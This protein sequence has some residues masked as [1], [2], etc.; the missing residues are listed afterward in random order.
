M[1]TDHSQNLQLAVKY[2]QL[3]RLAESEELCLAILAA[4]PNHADAMRLLGRLARQRGNNSAALELIQRAVAIHPSSADF[5]I[6]L[7]NVLMALNRR[8]EAA[9]TAQEAVNLDPNSAVAQTTL[10][11]ALAGI[12]RLRE[13]IN[14]WR[15]AVELRPGYIDAVECLGAAYR[16]LGSPA[17]AAAVYERFLASNP[18]PPGT[19]N[20]LAVTLGE[21]RQ[22][23]K[24][25]AAYRRGLELFPDN[26]MMHWGYSQA[27]LSAGNFEQGWE[28]FEWRR[29]M[30]GLGLDR[31]FPQ[32]QWDGANF[33]D[34]TLLLYTE[35]GF[36][37]AIHFIRFI[38]MVA[39]RG[40]K[41]I[42]ECQAELLRLFA[43]VP[44]LAVIVPRGRP[45][46][47]FDFQVALQSLPRIFK[48]KLES[49]P[50][51]IPYL[52]AFRQDASRWNDRLQAEMEAGLRVGLVWSGSNAVGEDQ[53]S[54]S[55]AIFSPLAKIPGVRFFSLQKGVEAGQI[56]PPQLHLTNYTGEIN[57]FADLAALIDNLDLVISVDTS[58]AHLCGAMG[59]PVRVL[60][61]YRS[62]FRWLRD[63]SDSPWYPTMKLFRQKTIGDWD[64]VIGTV[65]NDLSALAKEPISRNQIS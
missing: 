27:L 41:M 18:G 26:A 9:K 54:R 46:P 34:K 10:G 63:R 21:S 17:E 16:R 50:A 60:I 43:Q 52:S 5:R 53:R 36:G 3:G 4:E 7:A 55:V 14:F 62:D 28:E 20:N 32:P 37:D 48:T 1:S 64:E 22:F 35:G 49:I 8:D 24:S 29:K 47:E 40:G 38:P 23:E 59:K 25:Q 44:G 56:P 42:L 33:T 6:D 45:L 2:Q 15:R 58:A 51:K 31:Q 11:Q 39:S 30:P 57:D 13:S 61:P 65:A 12:G 19:H